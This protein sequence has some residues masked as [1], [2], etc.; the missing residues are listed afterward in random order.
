MK[1]V[2]SGGLLGHFDGRWPKRFC[3]IIEAYDAPHAEMWDLYLGLDMAL[4]EG[5]ST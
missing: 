4:R 5:L 1:V 3:R 2:G